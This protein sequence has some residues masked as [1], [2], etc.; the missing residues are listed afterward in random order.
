MRYTLVPTAE[1]NLYPNRLQL[2][3]L[4]KK[5]YGQ[6]LL[7]LMVLSLLSLWRP[8]PSKNIKEVSCEGL[9]L[10]GLYLPPEGDRLTGC[11]YTFVYGRR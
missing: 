2:S 11:R 9:Q 8:V 7:P 4:K 5:K 6:R 1:I 10:C 3:S